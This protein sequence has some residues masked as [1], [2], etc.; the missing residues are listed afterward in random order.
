M[1]SGSEVFVMESKTEKLGKKALN[2]FTKRITDEWF[3]FIQNDTALMKEYNEAVRE[4]T[5]QGVNSAL[6]KLITEA[7]HL[8][9]LGI[10]TK[11]KSI[12][13]KKYTKH[14]VQRSKKTS[15]TDDI[16]EQLK[17]TNLFAKPK[18]RKKTKLGKKPRQ[19]TKNM[20]ETGLFE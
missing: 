2:K 19:Q 14:K 9:N 10:E 15:S 16:P 17:G 12:L 4:S 1:Y 5:Q 3:T 13:L 8:E 6:G 7:Y 11:P 20:G 18:K